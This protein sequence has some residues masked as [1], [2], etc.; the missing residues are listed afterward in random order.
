MKM[1]ILCDNKPYETLF[2]DGNHENHD[3]LDRQRITEKFGGKVNQ[4][5]SKITHLRRG[6]IYTIN[7]KKVWVFGGAT[8]VDRDIRTEKLNWWPR[9]VASYAEMNH[10]IDNLKAIGNKVDYII[11]HTPPESVIDRLF[12]NSIDCPVAKYL[13]YIMSTV[14]YERWYC[15]HM[16]ID[17]YMEDIKLQLLYNS[18]VKLGDIDDYCER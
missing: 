15:G 11:T 10:G 13:D 4:L 12:G 2:V 18:I 3:F 1:R 16:H 14:K 9:E 7:G 6:E 8:S 17:R 5:S